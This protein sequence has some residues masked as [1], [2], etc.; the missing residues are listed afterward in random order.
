MLR[1]ALTGHHHHHS[2]CVAHTQWL[3]RVTAT[4][5]SR[6]PPGL[7]NPTSAPTARHQPFSTS[8]VCRQREGG[9]SEEEPSRL[10]NDS[11]NPSSSHVGHS[12]GPSP[13]PWSEAQAEGSGDVCIP[14]FPDLAGSSTNE[15]RV[16]RG[17]DDATQAEAS[18]AQ[19]NRSSTRPRTRTRTRVLRP[20]LIPPTFPP[21]LLFP[22]TNTPRSDPSSSSSANQ[23]RRSSQKGNATDETGAGAGSGSGST[24]I[25]LGGLRS[26]TLKTDIRLVFQ[27]FGE[28]KRILVHRGGRNADVVFAD[29]ESVRRA[30]HA[31]AEQ[32]LHVRGREV[33]VFRRKQNPQSA[34]DVDGGDGGVASHAP[35]YVRHEQGEDGDG[36]ND[37]AIFVAN[38]PAGTTR[39]EL[40]EVLTP[41]GKYEQLVMRMC[42]SPCH[43]YLE[44][45]FFFFFSRLTRSIR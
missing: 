6:A 16:L 18:P 2:L 26:N 39:E 37:G 3:S 45:S 13:S 8:L 14:V 28:V 17:D 31:Y 34:G 42:F 30:L 43:F 40:S 24:T 44:R 5:P 23:D 36:A 22:T 25:A 35:F 29:V 20:L 33:V 32:P 15:M 1:R 10:D 21:G 41:F 27:P 4:L 7:Q 12:S 38:F 19:A 11:Q 9:D